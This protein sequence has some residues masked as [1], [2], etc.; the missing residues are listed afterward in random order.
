MMTGVMVVTGAG[1]GIGAAIAVHAAKRGFKVAVN[2]SRSKDKAEAIVRKIMSA[3][4]EAIAIQADIG[5]EADIVRMFKETDDKLGQVTALVNNAGIDLPPKNTEDISLPEL[6][7]IFAV[8]VFG[9]ILCSREAIRRMSTERGGK[10]GAIVHI[11]SRA[12]GHGNLV[13]E[14]P[15]TATKGAM[16]GMT[17]V[18]AKEVA[19]SGIRVNCIRPGLILTDIFD[20]TGGHAALRE[21]AKTTVPMGRPGEPMEIATAAVW[22]CTDEASY[23]TGAILDVGG[24]R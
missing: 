24:G 2:Y 5:I 13:G 16:D 22:L 20:T 6:Q 11:S 19:K 8:N 3:G 1:R 9:A 7:S 17:L 10:G 23:V 14:V 21:R 18:M 12:S 15:Y 4:G